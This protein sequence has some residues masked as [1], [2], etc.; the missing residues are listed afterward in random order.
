[1]QM[2]CDSHL[3]CIACVCPLLSILTVQ[4]TEQLDNTTKYSVTGDHATGLSNS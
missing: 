4:L 2:S 3:A 1:M